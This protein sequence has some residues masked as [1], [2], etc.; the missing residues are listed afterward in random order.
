[1]AR[2]RIM[3]KGNGI[4]NPLIYL[5]AGI[6]IAVLL[7]GGWSF[8]QRRIAGEQARTLLLAPAPSGIPDILNATPGAP[9]PP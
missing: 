7:Y 6:G 1:M 8:Y 3:K 9:P 4:K 5:L 2:E